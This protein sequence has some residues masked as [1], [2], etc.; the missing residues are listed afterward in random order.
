MSRAQ[1]KQTLKLQLLALLLA[2]ALLWYSLNPAP[3]PVIHKRRKA[4]PPDGK[5]RN[6]AP[7][8][9]PAISPVGFRPM[10]GTELLPPADE[11]VDELEWP[12]FIDC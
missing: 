4:E 1:T 3:S 11:D 12:E 10:G 2:L 6:V 9:M 7:Q 8:S 5:K